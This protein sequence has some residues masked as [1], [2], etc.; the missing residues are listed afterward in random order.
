MKPHICCFRQNNVGIVESAEYSSRAEL[1]Y[2]ELFIEVKPDPSHDY[3][4]DPLPTD[5][6]SSHEFL[7]SSDDEE[8]DKHRNRALGQHIAFATEIFARQ[9]RSFAF[10]ISFAGSLARF[11]RWDRAG[12]VVS[13]AFDVRTR[14]EILC[15]FL[16]RFAQTDDVG[17]G[18][19]LT[20]EPAS[21]EEE[22][23]FRNAITEHVRFQL[24]CD[25]E[26]LEGAVSEHY[27][28]G[29]VTAI[30]VLERGEMATKGTI[31]RFLVSRPVASSTTPTGRGTRGWWGVQAST[32]KVIFLKDTWR[33]S[34][35]T[36]M[37]EGEVLLAMGNRG[38]RNI[39]SLV[40]HGDVPEY[41]PC[42][43]DDFVRE[44]FPT[45][46]V[47]VRLTST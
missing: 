47:Y 29:H 45:S 12:C 16:G 2:A 14:P 33:I 5:E 15:E 19:D 34:D 18:H 28:P 27:Q 1:G 22:K 10:S 11:I 13:E 8:V 24:A 32:G 21:A 23:L 36:Y 25:E 31:A 35:G 46:V 20:V 9:H 43:V 44:H 4:V 3:F 17:R 7:L 38:V 42:A 37:T 6:P 30:Y 41:V 40:W 39:P 26:A